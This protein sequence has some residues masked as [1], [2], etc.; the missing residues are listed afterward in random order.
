MDLRHL[1][2]I[3]IALAMDALG[4]TLSI[5][6]N[7]RVRR[8]SKIKEGNKS[9]IEAEECSKEYGIGYGGIYT[10]FKGQVGSSVGRKGKGE[11][12][13]I[14]DEENIIG[15][16]ILNE[17]KLMNEI[18]HFNYE[19]TKKNIIK[20]LRDI[21]T[22]PNLKEQFDFTIFLSQCKKNKDV[23]VDYSLIKNIIGAKEFIKEIYNKRLHYTNEKFSWK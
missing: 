6:L 14:N 16:K 12:F 18:T 22:T 3:G 21:E 10:A 13:E 23:L 7:P 15:Y 5:G 2:I 4:V 19:D 17:F 20:V 11:N 9:F 8:D 1:I